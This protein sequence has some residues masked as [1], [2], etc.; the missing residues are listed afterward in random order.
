MAKSGPGE[1]AQGI[2]FWPW[3]FSFEHGDLLSEGQNFERSIPST[4]K[5]HSDADKE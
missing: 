2:Q 4:A 5:K 1:S 3:P